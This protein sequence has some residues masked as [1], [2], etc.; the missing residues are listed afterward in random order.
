MH[1]K[2]WLLRSISFLIGVCLMVSCN[3]RSNTDYL[4]ETKRDSTPEMLISVNKQLVE[5]DSL[6][7]ARYAKRRQWNMSLTRTGMWYQIIERGKGPVA[8]DNSRITIAYT[9]ESITGATYYHSDSLGL[10][11]FIVGKERVEAGLH[12]AAKMLHE[13]DSACF[14][15][16]PHLAFGLMGDEN[17]IGPRA[18]LVY[19]LRVKQVKLPANKKN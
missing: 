13:G 3:Y 11:S 5:N 15:L 18:I 6:I 10:K 14:I 7:I 16:P 2:F 19:H 1:K 8:I 12:E 4:Y 9:C 17:K